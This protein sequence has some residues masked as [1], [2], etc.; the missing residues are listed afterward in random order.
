M[1]SRQS[2]F[3]VFRERHSSANSVMQVWHDVHRTCDV[4][5]L[6]GQAPTDLQ[7]QEQALGP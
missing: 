3:P 4:I 5:F 7:L 1:L 2:R 6:A